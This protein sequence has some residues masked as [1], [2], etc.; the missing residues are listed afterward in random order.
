MKTVLGQ[1]PDETLVQ[2]LAE[3]FSA[4]MRVKMLASEKLNQDA[5]RF[6]RST[7]GAIAHYLASG[8]DG[9]ELR[10]LC[11][12]LGIDLLFSGIQGSPASK[13]QLVADILALKRFAVE[14]TCL[15]GDAMND[16][17]AARA[18]RVKFFGYNNPALREH[19]DLYL[20]AFSEFPLS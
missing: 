4:I 13:P 17:E 9:N 12:A 6:I 10:Y 1:D 5:L 11:K 19:A 18:N 14:E 16:L 15:I 8:S 2:Q 7:Q 3:S 20:N